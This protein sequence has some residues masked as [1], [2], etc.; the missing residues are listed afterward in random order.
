V[1]SGW[2]APTALIGG[3][4]PIRRTEI[5]RRHKNGGVTRQAEVPVGMVHTLYLE[6][7]ATT[8][9]IIEQSCTQS[10]RLYAVSLPVQIS[11]PARTPCKFKECIQQINERINLFVCLCIFVMRSYLILI[12]FELPTCSFT[13]C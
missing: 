5:G 11:I 12:L 9:S 13:T 2:V 4:R 8:Q 3:K 1:R 10:C 6:T 7:R